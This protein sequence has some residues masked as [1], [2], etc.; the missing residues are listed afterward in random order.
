MPRIATRARTEAGSRTSVVKMNVGSNSSSRRV[1]PD[2]A[3]ASDTRDLTTS[4]GAPPARGSGLP[5]HSQEPERDHHDRSG[6]GEAG[7]V[8]DCGPATE[9]MLDQPWG[10]ALHEGASYIV[11]MANRRIRMV[12]P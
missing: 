6:T 3:G 8:G 1:S 2:L 10:I 7:Y 5:G 9:A 12:V 11:D 4:S